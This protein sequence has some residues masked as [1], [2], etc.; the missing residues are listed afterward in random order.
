MVL[1]LVVTMVSQKG[2]VGLIWCSLD[3]MVMMMTLGA[4]NEV[5]RSDHLLF[6]CLL[7]SHSFHFAVQT[8]SASFPDDLHRLPRCAFD[9]CLIH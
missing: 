9:E 7:L 1:M 2:R 4:F 3:R 6:I 5:L 8:R